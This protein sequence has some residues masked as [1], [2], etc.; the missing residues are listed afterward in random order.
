MVF[1]SLMIIAISFLIVSSEIKINA[2]KEVSLHIPR[3]Y[4]CQ[5]VVISDI[6]IDPTRPTYNDNVSVYAKVSGAS[7]VFLNWTDG[8]YHYVE[9]E[10]IE[11]L[12]N[13]YRAII[14]RHN[15]GYTIYF[16][17]E[18]NDSS[19]SWYY[20]TWYYYFVDDF[21]PPIFTYGSKIEGDY[22]ALTT[23]EFKAN[24]TDPDY[25]KSSGVKIMQIYFEYGSD[26]ETFPNTK[27]VD[28]T[29]DGE[30]WK[31][32]VLFDYSG[33]YR[34]FYQW[35][36]YAEN[37]DY[38]GDYYSYFRVVKRK[39]MIIAPENISVYYSD[40][41]SLT[42]RLYDINGSRGIQGKEVVLELY[43][44]DTESWE[45]L[46]GEFIFTNET[47][48]VT[49]DLLADLEVGNY[50]LRA[51]FYGSPC[52][53]SSNSIINLRI[54]PEKIKI[55]IDK[56]AIEEYNF[57]IQ[58]SI[59]DDENNP[60]VVGTVYILNDD[61]QL[62][63]SK[64][65]TLDDNGNVELQLNLY[66]FNIW[67][68]ESKFYFVNITISFN[69]KNYEFTT[70]K[71]ILEVKATIFNLSYNKNI[72]QGETLNITLIANDPDN[73]LQIWVSIDNQEV[74]SKT[75]NKEI[76]VINITYDIPINMK[77]GYHT[78]KI[79]ARDNM[80][81]EYVYRKQFEVK[82]T[83]IILEYDW[84]M[85]GSILI[86]QGNVSYDI[87]YPTENIT[88]MVI[89]NLEHTYT[90]NN[91][92]G[93]F[94]LEIETKD[95]VSDTFSLK[96][97]ATDPYGHQSE[98]QLIYI[99]PFTENKENSN[100]GFLY[101]VITISGFIGAIASGIIIYIHYKGK[102]KKR[103]IIEEEEEKMPEDV[104]L[105]KGDDDNG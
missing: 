67:Q 35:S 53:D 55:S 99:T 42:V 38:N 24:I 85:N 68:N 57:S 75:P 29:Y 39:T 46:M 9:M 86:V 64:Q 37:W 63:A 65:I 105:Y 103:V 45:Y 54:L 43:D 78:I 71:F 60:S 4:K 28:M 80:G 97:V 81:Y 13:K 7:K 66:H 89:I 36:D 79:E 59:I 14:P 27:V 23:I 8:S 31:A 50:L 10:L 98:S 21:T 102:N 49:F 16:R 47:G 96:V 34:Y 82:S 73:I 52:Y 90:T 3:R 62:I 70:K 104:I 44:N 48:Y 76:L 77:V 100:N 58:V 84:D 92:E 25:P 94:Y 12:N 88:I 11:P 101:N 19:D 20:S 91:T 72:K 17:I 87:S 69:G 15:Y 26:N 2:P 51:K 22:L 41:F 33:Y 6:S 40:G 1:F 5:D 83:N 30:Y 56:E 32:S 74:C 93:M 18:A 61:G 95:I